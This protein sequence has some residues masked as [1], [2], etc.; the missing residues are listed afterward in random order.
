MSVIKSTVHAF[1]GFITTDSEDAQ[2]E[3]FEAEDDEKSVITS[4]QLV[5]QLFPDQALMLCNRSHPKLL[6]VSQNSK[7]VLGIASAE[8]CSLSVFDF[9]KLVHPEDINGLKQC[10]NFINQAEPY[11]PLT[12]RFVLHYRF[13][14]T[15]GKFVPI[16]DEKLAIKSE[17]GKYIYFTLFRKLN[18][19]HKFFNVRLDIDQ[20]SKGVLIK[21]YS[22]NPRQ[23]AQQ[24]TPRQNDIVRLIIRGLSNQEIADQLNLSINTIKNHKRVLFKRTN[25]KSSIE[26]ATY[27]RDKAVSETL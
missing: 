16:R 22:Y 23:R 15:S 6:Y 17:N 12:H 9:F 19:E 18:Q 3:K 5:E 8:F 7:D 25:V 26:L 11:D 4:L 24:I 21:I 2:Y 20:Y 14:T 13:L 27:A 1:V 10:F